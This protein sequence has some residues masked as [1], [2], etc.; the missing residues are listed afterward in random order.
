MANNVKINYNAIVNSLKNQVAILSKEIVD[1]QASGEPYY[2]EIFS[3]LVG[4][5]IYVDDE[6][7]FLKRLELKDNGIYVTVKFGN[8]STNFGGS[9][10]SISLEI[11]GTKNKIKP[12]QAFFSAFCS[13]WSLSHLEGDEQ[14][15]QIWVTPSVSSNFNEVKDGFRTLFSVS[16]TLIIGRSTIRLGTITY[17][18][19]PNEEDVENI[20]FMSYQDNY[21]ASL[22]PQPFGN[23]C[24]FTVS[25]N[26]F[27]TDSFSISTYLIDCKLIQDC[28]ALKGLRKRENGVYTPSTSAKKPNDDFVLYLTF[29]NGYTNYSPDNEESDP[30]DDV[31]GSKLFST[32]KCSSISI[33]QRIDGIATITLAFSH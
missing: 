32:Y 8:A 16:G 1:G 12:A 6:Q 18:Y 14:T 29:S 23:T 28:L 30:N 24:G 9:M 2:T 26:N 19:G 22:S 15:N 7:S 4:T 33:Q 3:Y 31:K 10:C 11:L 27:S 21:G 13:R 5:E 20:D 25:E 17:K